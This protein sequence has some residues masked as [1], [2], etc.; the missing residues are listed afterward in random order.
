MGQWR[1]AAPGLQKFPRTA[2]AVPVRVS[3]VDPEVDPA[4]G[5][6]FFR[7]AE[8]TTGNLSRGGV[9]VR[10]WEPLASGRRVV[11][12]LDLSDARDASDELQ[13]VGRVVWARRQIV[14]KG[15]AVEQPGYGVEF[16]GGTR[17][18]LERLDRHLNRMALRAPQRRS[19]VPSPPPPRA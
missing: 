11:V 13:I 16:T 19:D 17:D 3:T 1:Q 4:S 15:D 14:P 18:E 7:S 9:Y 12:T 2:T 5:R 10:S 6:T 8:E